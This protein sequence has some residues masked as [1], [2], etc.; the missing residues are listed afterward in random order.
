MGRLAA[1]A[2][3]RHARAVTEPGWALP[4]TSIADLTFAEI[5]AERAEAK[6]AS[7]AWLYERDVVQRRRDDID[8]LRKIALFDSL[9]DWLGSQRAAEVVRLL[10]GTDPATIL[11]DE[12]DLAA[13]LTEWFTQRRRISRFQARDVAQPFVPNLEARHD[14][15]WR[16]QARHL[17]TA[18]TRPA[19][20]HPRLCRLA[21]TLAAGALAGS[22]E[23]AVLENLPAESHV[24]I[25]RHILG[26]YHAHRADAVNEKWSRL[27]RRERRSLTRD[28]LQSDYDGQHLLICDT[29]ALTYPLPSGGDSV[30][31][32]CTYCDGSILSWS[33][34]VKAPS[35]D[36]HLQ[37]IRLR[38]GWGLSPSAADQVASMSPKA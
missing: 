26:D 19:E 3:I 11:N 20:A 15:I 25:Q 1:D 14:D 2:A 22:N 12:P 29:C 18:G 16:E 23:F 7:D 6:E 38:A 36:Q 28:Q 5:L 37:A 8:A 9:P 27:G 31:G 30:D 32:R 33:D 24:E 34:R 10:I 21:A 13:Q 17:L 35:L 4:D